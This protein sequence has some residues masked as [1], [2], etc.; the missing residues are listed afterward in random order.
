MCTHKKYLFHSRVMFVS[1]SGELVAKTYDVSN[2]K[3]MY[4]ENYSRCI[5]HDIYVFMY[6]ETYINK[7]MYMYSCRYVEKR[8]RA[9]R[10]T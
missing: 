6:K 5:M 8:L 9:G 3:I 2:Y 1:V 7:K 10:Y 4:F